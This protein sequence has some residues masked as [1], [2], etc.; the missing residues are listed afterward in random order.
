MCPEDG[1]N[2][3]LQ[4]EGAEN[5][6]LHDDITQKITIRIITDVK[7]SHINLKVSTNYVLQIRTC[8]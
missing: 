5:T 7:V 4:D 1:G 6:G 3:F 2:K 8:Y